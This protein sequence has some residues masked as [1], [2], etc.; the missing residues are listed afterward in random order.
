M[1]AMLNLDKNWI[2]LA[3]MLQQSNDQIM[4]FLGNDLLHIHNLDSFLE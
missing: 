2:D 3:P 1:G 4:I